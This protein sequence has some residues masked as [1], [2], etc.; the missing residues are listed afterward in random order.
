M[1]NPR[2]AR[3]S[4]HRISTPVISLLRN[5]QER[6]TRSENYFPLFIFFFFFSFYGFHFFAN[7]FK[8]RI[9]PRTFVALP[10]PTV[11][12]IPMPDR[13]FD[14]QFV[15]PEVFI[16][17][18]GFLRRDS[19][20]LLRLSRLQRS[21]SQGLLG[22]QVYPTALSNNSQVISGTTLE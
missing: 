17:S 3:T 20:R 6:Q 2:F 19:G 14:M 18:T 21:A 16:V 8:K 13:S 22:A 4:Q 10:L 7:T 9:K 5:L 15:P 12:P 1:G 11:I